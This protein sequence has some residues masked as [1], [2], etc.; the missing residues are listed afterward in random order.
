MDMS[1]DLHLW[2]DYAARDVASTTRSP[3]GIVVTYAG[4]GAGAVIINVIIAIVVVVVVVV[5]V[6]AIGAGAVAAVA[7]IIVANAGDVV[8]ATGRGRALGRFGCLEERGLR[9][10]DGSRER[11][12][13]ARSG[14]QRRTPGGC[15]VRR[16]LACIRP[17]TLTWRRHVVLMSFFLSFSLSLPHKGAVFWRVCR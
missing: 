10:T 5:V 3:G 16:G 12:P 6:V 2:V 9:T 13:S 14:T 17:M 7:E 4:A 1:R 11:A 15:A 8:I